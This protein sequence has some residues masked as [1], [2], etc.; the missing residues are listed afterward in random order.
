MHQHTH[1][2][3]MHHSPEFSL[4]FSGLAKNA[5]MH[6]TLHVVEKLQYTHSMPV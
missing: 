4:D 1:Q 6:T 3:G 5:T 2:A